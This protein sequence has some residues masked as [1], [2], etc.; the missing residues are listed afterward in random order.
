[1]YGLECEKAFDDNPSTYWI[2]A[3]SWQQQEITKEGLLAYSDH[4]T[5]EMKR[6]EAIQYTLLLDKSIGLRKIMLKQFNI[7]HGFTNRIR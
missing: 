1:M 3:S 6:G 5:E 7:G 4:E 2:P